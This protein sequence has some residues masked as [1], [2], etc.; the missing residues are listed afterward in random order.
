MDKYF[1]CFIISVTSSLSYYIVRC[2]FFVAIWHLL[3]D[4]MSLA[5][6]G[7]SLLVGVFIWLLFNFATSLWFYLCMN[8]L[9]MS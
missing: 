7:M 1:S 2:D 6:E 8:K 9:M 5:L 3:D 4:E